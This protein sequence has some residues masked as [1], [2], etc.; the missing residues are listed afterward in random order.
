MKI[1]NYIIAVFVSLFSVGMIN[2]TT[3][4][5]QPSLTTISG[6]K[7]IIVKHTNNGDFYLTGKTEK[8]FTLENLDDE[9]A[10]CSLQE[11]HNNNNTDRYFKFHF[12]NNKSYLSVSGDYLSDYKHEEAFK[13]LKVDKSYPE[14]VFPQSHRDKFI[15]KL[16]VN[17]DG[18]VHLGQSSHNYKL[19]LVK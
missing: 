13:M 8:P 15:V 17:K 9:T 2:Q 18:T 14:Y 3:A 10:Y 7:F 11:M 19:Y 1:K 5:I 16:K 4:Q 12:E 6:H